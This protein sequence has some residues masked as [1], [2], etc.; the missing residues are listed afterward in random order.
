MPPEPNPDRLRLVVEPDADDTR[1]MSGEGVERQGRDDLV[2]LER[3]ADDSDYEFEDEEE[4]EARHSA[5]P[6]SLGI[7]AVLGF[8]AV[9]W[10]AY[11]GVLGVDSEQAI[12]LIQADAGPIKTRPTAPGGLEVPH[13][14][15]LVLNEITPDPQKPQVERLLPPPEVPKPPVAPAPIQE[16]VAQGQ[17]VQEQAVQ[18]EAVRQPGAA[19]APA[20]AQAQE[21]PATAT[22][23]DQG[24]SLPLATAAGPETAPA[25]APAPEPAAPAPDPQVPAAAPKASP[26][27]A[28]APAP[29]PEL[30][31]PAA[32]APTPTATQTAALTE[33]YLV[34]LASLKDKN[35]IGGEWVRLQKTYPSVLNQKKLVL[36]TADL[37]AKGVY[38][39]LRV[40][41]FKDKASA[42]ATC[43][44]LKARNQACIVIRP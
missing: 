13:Q 19:T 29:K 4:P 32:K 18:Q 23:Q 14:D 40:G 11:Q 27:V 3:L 8:A 9:G 12:P 22:G 42:A 34:Q 2:E 37:G 25:A 1:V 20:T 24:A 28:E 10:F 5:L 15:K 26:T 43:Q 41:Y 35:L 36:Q 16:Q 17:V 44:A 21:Q 7:A 38:H 31:A 30:V 33:G 39:R 6:I